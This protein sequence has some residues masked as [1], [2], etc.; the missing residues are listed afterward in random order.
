MAKFKRRKTQFQ[1]RL[2]IISYCMALPGS[3]LTDGRHI[4]I[5]KD[6]VKLLA[7]EGNMAPEQVEKYIEVY[8][9]K[10]IKGLMNMHGRYIAKEGFTEDDEAYAENFLEEVRNEVRKANEARN[11]AMLQNMMVQNNR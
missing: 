2:L 9:E 5:T 1:D 4:S 6:E 10:G 3:Q 11:M 7:Q 8:E